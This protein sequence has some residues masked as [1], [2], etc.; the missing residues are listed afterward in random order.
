MAQSLA[1]RGRPWRRGAPDRAR[2]RLARTF[3]QPIQLAYVLLGQVSVFRTVG[4]REAA[5]ATLA[6]ARSVLDRCPDPGI[7]AETLVPSSDQRRSAASDPKTRAH[8]RELGVLKLL[9]SDLSE[10]DIGRELFVSHSTV[11]SH[12]RSIY[13]KLAVRSRAEALDRSHELDLR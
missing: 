11:H 8:P 1:A 5:T 2:H 13:R 10:R 9:D 4:E 12:V 7:L 3:G 6:D